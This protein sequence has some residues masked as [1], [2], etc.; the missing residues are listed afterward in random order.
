[1]YTIIICSY[2]MYYYAYTYVCTY[3]CLCICIMVVVGTLRTYAFVH[4]NVCMYIPYNACTVHKCIHA[5][6]TCTVLYVL[7]MITMYSV[8]RTTVVS[9][10]VSAVSSL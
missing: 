9:M 3:I 1:M 8:Y 10:R 2:M 6:I 7:Y 4:P 5:C